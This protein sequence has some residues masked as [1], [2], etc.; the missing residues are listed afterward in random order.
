MSTSRAVALRRRLSREEESAL[1]P[2]EVAQELA[3]LQMKFYIKSFGTLEAADYPSSLRMLSQSTQGA[4]L[5]SH[6]ALQKTLS[7]VLSK[8]VRHQARSL[9]RMGEDHLGG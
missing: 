9:R 2:E 6:A 3:L 1:S 8:E 5:V 7:R 4:E